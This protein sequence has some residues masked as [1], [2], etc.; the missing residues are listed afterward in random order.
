MDAAILRRLHLALGSRSY[1]IVVGDGLLHQAGTLIAPVLQHPRTI[2]VTDA[3]VVDPYLKILKQSLSTSGIVVDHIIVP[4]GEATK[5]FAELQRICEMA[6]ELGMDRATTLIALGG[7]VVGDLTGFAAS[8]LLRGVDFIQIPTTL[9]AQVDSSVGGKTAIDC[10]AGKN[11]VGSFH[12]PR[13]VIADT[14]TLNTLPRRDLIGGYAEIVKYGFIR[15][16]GFFNWLEDH[17]REVLSGNSE[18]RTE[19]ILTSCRHKAEV[20]AMDEKEVGDRALLNFGHT[21]AHALEAETGFGSVLLHGE[22]VAI[23]M[24]MAFD[25]S[26]RLGLCSMGDADRARQHLQG[27]GLPVTLPNLRQQTWHLTAL[28]QRMARDK[29]AMDGKLTFILTKGIGHAFVARDIPHQEVESF[30]SDAIG[31]AAA[32]SR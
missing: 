4:S 9:L 13:L 8:I 24:I 26:V 30:L 16:L 23:G 7:G 22:A 17:A 27:L 12:Q 1:D 2:I 3:A 32:T 6:L 5:S 21:F 14:E 10:E 25:F 29:K 31:D 18:L 19:A 11:L 28:L 15:D 20:V